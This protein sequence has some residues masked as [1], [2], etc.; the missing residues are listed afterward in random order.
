M[1]FNIVINIYACSCII[2]IYNNFFIW[3][4]YVRDCLDQIVVYLVL[5]WYSYE[6]NYT[7]WSK[8]TIKMTTQRIYDPL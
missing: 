5:L 2:F 1:L 8:S 7:F 6:Q 3:L 4:V